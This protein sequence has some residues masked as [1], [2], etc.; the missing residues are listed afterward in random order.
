[1]TCTNCRR[2]I[3]EWRE[4]H[5]EIGAARLCCDCVATEPEPVE[6]KQPKPAVEPL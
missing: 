2:T 5:Y 4:S 3:H 6:P 1:M